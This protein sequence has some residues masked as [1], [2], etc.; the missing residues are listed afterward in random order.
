MKA[1]R[2]ERGMTAGSVVLL[3]LLGGVLALVG[4]RLIPVYLNHFKVVSALESL[5]EQPE[6]GQMSNMEVWNRLSGRFEVDDVDFLERDDVQIQPTRYGKTVSV[7][8]EVR[9]HV[10]GN[11]DAVAQFSHTVEL[12]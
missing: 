6:P 9:R 10:L 2:G 11:V 3:L 1:G 12:R 7:D 4:L 5:T 8:Y